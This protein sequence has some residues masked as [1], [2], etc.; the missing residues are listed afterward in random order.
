MMRSPGMRQFS[1][2]SSA[3]GRALDAEL[4]LLRADDEALV[5]LVHHER[6]DAVG[7]L[8]R[9]GH[10]H[11]GVPGRLAAVGDPA[12]GAVEHPVVAVGLG[13]GAHR[14]GV[15]AGL[16][17]GQRVGRHRL[18]VDAIDGSTCFLSSSEPRRIRPIVPSLLTAGIS[19][20][21]R[22]DA[23][24]LLDHDARG[25]RVGALAAVLLGDVHGVEARRV[26][27]R[28]APPRGSAR[29][30]R[31]PRRSG[32]ISFSA[33]ARIAARSSSCSSVSLNRS[34]SGLPAMRSNSNRHAVPYQVVDLRPPYPGRRAQRRGIAQF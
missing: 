10:R 19:D 8:V 28:R 34:K 17:L 13:A 21:E 14:G 27:A 18:A 6:R 7:A 3:V 12:L 33:S 29:S 23:G 24:D 26:R 25:D 30:R 4:V 9:V 20:D 31:R 22:A 11:D 5:V 1:K 32:A 15:G 2:Y 16:P